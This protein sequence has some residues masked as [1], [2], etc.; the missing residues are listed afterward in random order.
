LVL[1]GIQNEQLG[2]GV[3]EGG[4]QISGICNV[5]LRPGVYV[6]KGGGLSVS[7]AC[8]LSGAEV[9]ILNIP[10]MATDVIDIDGMIDI[11]PPTSLD[12]VFEPFNGISI[13]QAPDSN[14][15]IKLG[16]I[17]EITL[18]GTMYAPGAKVTIG[19]NSELHINRDTVN[20]LPGRAILSDL[21]LE[22]NGGLLFNS[23]SRRPR[24]WMN[25]DRSR[26]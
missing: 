13:Y 10:S 6:L 21:A 15:P 11:T 1:K 7:G 17:S 23:P 4:I 9:V 8:S 5:S 24:P 3:Y 20:N 18:G 26:R 19:G 25:S 12:D 16:G 14:A 22:G 2:P